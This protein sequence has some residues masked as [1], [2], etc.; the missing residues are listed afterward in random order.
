MFV[1][2]LFFPVYCA[3][4]GKEGNWVCDECLKNIKIEKICL[5]PV[6]HNSADGVCEKCKAV[7]YLDGVTALFSYREGD[8]ISK[9][10]KDFKYQYAVEIEDVW[11]KVIISYGR[12]QP[13]FTIVP[14]PLHSR[15][16]RERGF[17]QS[18]K[19]ADILANAY[20]LEL[21]DG[22]FRIRYTTQQAK[23]SG[24]ERR[25]N[26]YSAFAWKTKNSA[27][28][29]VLLIDDVFTTGATMQECA[30][31]LKENGSEKVCGFVLA[32]G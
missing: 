7:S 28:K 25:K 31:K 8:V 27:P 23:L 20:G 18:K 11:K 14:V 21:S 19:L 30:K 3:G 9:L 26:L 4:C 32:R 2:D 22:L 1:K 15:R 6:C 24:E 12:I 13:D 29:N 16:E 10:I 5:C 17:N